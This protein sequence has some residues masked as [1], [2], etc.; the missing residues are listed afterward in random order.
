[1][2]A[3]TEESFQSGAAVELLRLLEALA[4]HSPV[5][6]TAVLQSPHALALLRS[7]S[8]SLS[9]LDAV[10]RLLATLSQTQTVTAATSEG[11]T[12]TTKALLDSFL[13]LVSDTPLAD[14]NEDE[15]PSE[16]DALLRM[17]QVKCTC[18]Y[19]FQISFMILLC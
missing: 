18:N 16:G 2:D 8:A 9:L 13:E 1:L 3:C 15:K 5:T 10:A 11:G 7:L 12:S 4:T 6:A 14:P 19:Y 17:A